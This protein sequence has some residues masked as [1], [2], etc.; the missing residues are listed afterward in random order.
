M[1]EARVIATVTIPMARL[2]VPC[3]VLRY[4]CL[5]ACLSA[6]VS[7]VPYRYVSQVISLHFQFINHAHIV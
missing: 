4:R 6:C 5:P 2:I 7:I 1:D 3:H